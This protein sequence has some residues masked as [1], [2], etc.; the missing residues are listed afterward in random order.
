MEALRVDPS[1]GRGREEVDC[2]AALGEG[3]QRFEHRL[4]L[5]LR[6]DDVPV[7]GALAPRRQSKNGEVVALGGAAREDDIFR[8]RIRARSRATCSRARLDGAFGAR[9]EVVGAAASVPVFV[10]HETHDEFGN[11]GIDRGCGVTV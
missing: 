8:T 2:E 7:V 4:V 5:D 11:P 10:H 6:R 1:S 3:L 9:A